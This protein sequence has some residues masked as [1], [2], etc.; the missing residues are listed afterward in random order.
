MRKINSI[1]IERFKKEKV[2]ITV[3]SYKQVEECSEILQSAKA[4]SYLAD[5]IFS[6]PYYI[7]IQDGID[8][9]SF[10]KDFHYE[11]DEEILF[12]NLQKEIIQRSDK[13]ELI[14]EG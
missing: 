6:S 3:N 12:V 1:D 10:R 7:S 2:F 4:W 9:H 11:N 8:A 5:I 13:I 14:D